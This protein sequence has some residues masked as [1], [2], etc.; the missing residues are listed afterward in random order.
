MPKFLVDDGLRHHQNGA[1]I[2]FERV[3]HIGA[4]IDRR[5]GHVDGNDD[6]GEPAHAIEGQ[7]IGRAAV[8]HH[9]AFEHDRPADARDCHRRGDRRPQRAGRDCGLSPGIEVGC[10]DRE[11]DRQRSKIFRHA[12]G[13]KLRAEFL[14]IDQAG[15]AKA[16]GDQRSDT[17]ACACGQKLAEQSGAIPRQRRDMCADLLAAHAG[18]IG[19]AEKG[20]DR[21]AG[22]RNR[23]DAHVVERFHH[24]DMR[25]PARAAAAE[26]Q[27]YGFHRA[28]ASCAKRHAVAASGRIM[29]ALA[30]AWSLVAVPSRTRPM[31]PCRIAAIRKKL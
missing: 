8:H 24:R 28:P 15:A 17:S 27:S 22:N 30:G 12:V 23:T 19:R 18:G 3:R 6:I 7:R 20:A 25:Q 4:V 13:K 9:T 21:G 26:R 1:E 14:R 29:S 5:T 11:R 16:R 31:M 10:D 2:T